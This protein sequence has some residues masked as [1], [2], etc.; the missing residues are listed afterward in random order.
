MSKRGNYNCL[1]LAILLI[2]FGALGCFKSAADG[3]F[4]FKPGQYV[5]KEPIE[6]SRDSRRLYYSYNLHAEGWAYIT[7]VDD[8]G[9]DAT[10]GRGTFSEYRQI[11]NEIRFFALPG[12]HEEVYDGIF[13]VPGVV[14]L[15]ETTL[16]QDR[17]GDKLKYKGPALTI[18]PK[19]PVLEL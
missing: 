19:L 8:N 9:T 16:R 18:K 17:T 4:V 11:A 14:I 12:Q 1:S 5:A 2:C 13:E 15:S 10:G 6:S 7:I 3:S